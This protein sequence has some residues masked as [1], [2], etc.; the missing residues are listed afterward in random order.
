MSYQALARKWRPRRFADMVGQEHVRRALGNALAG[1]RLH[2]AYLFTGTRGVGKTTVA[3]LFAKA[4]NC[5]RGVSA[6]PCG[7]CGACTAIDAGR[8]MDLIE[9]DAASRTGV[10]D[11]R[12]LLENVQYAPTQGRYKVYLIDEVHMFSKSSFNALLK[13]LEEPP[14]HVK[15]LLATTDPQKIPA[16]ILS[17]C[18]QFNLRALTPEQV[19]G[20]LTRVLEAEHIAPDAAA[21]ELLARTAA[22]SMRDALSLLDQALAHGGGQ[23]QADAVRAMLGTLDRSHAPRLLQALADGDG[24]ALLAALAEANAQ[25]ADPGAVLDELLRLLHQIA[26]CQ[27]V[28]GATLAADADPAAVQALAA[29]LPAEDVQLYYQMALLGRRDLPLAPDPASGLEMLLLRLLVFR[30]A[31]GMDEAA[32]APRRAP[33]EQAAAQPQRSAEPA[34]PAAAAAPSAN[35]APAVRSS[36]RRED[37][38]SAIVSRLGLRGAAQQL[39]QHC[40]LRHRQDE[41]FELAVDARSRSLLTATTRQALTDALSNLIGRPARVDFGVDTDAADTPAQQLARAEAER[42]A[43]ARAALEDDPVVRGLM[44]TLDARLLDGTAS[45]D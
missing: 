28:P 1:D 43:R 17:R 20:Q 39:A 34:R 19:A 32:S 45:T 41:H 5:E 8:F 35:D 25:A 30:P 26:L 31:G 6:E 11:T 2:H 40:V 14:P 13:T 44:H 38:W 7:E 33:A 9:V 22:G 12:E 36:A 24:A 18:L 15:F 27:A 4:L 42:A 23:L 3:R 21:V 16:T 10:D 29:R 37:D